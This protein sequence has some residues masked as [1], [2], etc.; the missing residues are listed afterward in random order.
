MSYRKF[1]RIFLYDKSPPGR[2]RTPRIRKMV[3]DATALR[4]ECTLKRTL[5]YADF[6]RKGYMELDEMEKWVLYQVE[7][8]EWYAVLHELAMA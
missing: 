2:M 8:N 7:G 3:A 6:R 5:F 4:R 1:L